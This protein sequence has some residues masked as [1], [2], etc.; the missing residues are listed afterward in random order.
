MVR[1]LVS[2]I[3][4]TYNRRDIIVEAIESALNQTYKN[5]EVII[6][7]NNST[8]GTYEFL[9]EKYRAVDFIKLYKNEENLGPV[10]NWEKCL[11][12][13]DGE[14]C[15]ILWSDDLMEATFIEKA[16]EILN[17]ENE[18]AFVY[19]KVSKVQ[20]GDKC[21]Y[22]TIS[23][24]LGQTGKYSK[25][26]FI[27]KTCKSDWS[28]P[29]SPGCALFRT[30]DIKII[31]KI[32]NCFCIDYMSTGAGPD[33]LIYLFSM[34]NYKYVY[35]IDEVLNFFRVHG[36]SITC[37]GIDLYYSYMTA[38]LYYVKEVAP[39]RK[40]EKILIENIVLNSIQKGEKA[41]TIKR[42]IKQFDKDIGNIEFWL[43]YLRMWNKY[44][45]E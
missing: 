35:Y 4:P 28:V 21:N 17:Q 44:I 16:I 10:R 36:G 38:K 34:L 9:Q 15:K 25:N 40:C 19:S 37:S 7:D 1:G 41:G 30:Q 26:V 11:R 2:I 13:S 43:I 20:I 12:Y 24:S 23:Y 6:V 8:D 32:P 22:G 3:I 42:L 29:V 18:V 14:Y 45:N 31:E 39:N 27:N 5:I 33:V